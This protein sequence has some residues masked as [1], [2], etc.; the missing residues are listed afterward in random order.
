MNR[1]D[2]SLL[3]SAG[4]G[5][6]ATGLHATAAPNA[7]SHVAT[8]AKAAA[9]A[10]T[11]AGAGLARKE[12]K[13]WAR[14]HFRGFENILLPSFTPDLEQLDEAGIRLDVRNS[15]AHGFFSSLA[16]CIALTPEESKRFV[17]IATDEAAGRISIA[18][19][20]GGAG[21]ATHDLDLIAHAERVGCSHMILDLPREGSAADLIRL[22]TELCEHT[23]MGIYLW[24]AQV[25]DFKR[26]HPSGIPFEVFDA[27]APLPN[28]I[29]LKAG[30]PDPAV[31]FQLF[32]RYNDQMLIGALM[33]D[34][35][36][37]GVKAFSQQ[38]SGAW[39][40]EAVQTPQKRYAVE[41]FSLLT[42][43]KY[44]PAMSLYW[45]HLAP[46]FGA[47]MKVLGPLMPRGGHPWE[48]L[49]VY[50][51]LGGGNGGRMRPDK[52]Q[53]VALPAVTQAD[54]DAVAGVF[55]SVGLEP[56]ELP[57]QAF[58]VGRAA[59]EKGARL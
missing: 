38:W 4:A 35:M 26:F 2:F 17:E 49:K 18:L 19:A 59:Y 54:L 39:T 52:E 27:L 10:R 42:E 16:A 8:A 45:T 57:L 14:Q 43:G 40:V 41:F 58:Q 15:I 21:L 33:L 13:A 25:H 44:E 6:L 7:T 56:A 5:A 31:I 22:A 24:A 51:F 29:A 12:R 3:A 46:A 23:N 48:H 36:P 11:G 30:S 28:I 20:E 55:R 1:R 47:M 37:M 34:I 32:E 50:Q 53:A 9:A